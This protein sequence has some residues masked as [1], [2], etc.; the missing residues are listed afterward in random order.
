M[1]SIDSVRRS[2]S[3]TL[4]EI[5]ATQKG[6]GIDACDPGDREA[7]DIV[8]RIERRLLSRPAPK[9]ETAA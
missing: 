9:K 6:L 1:A 4:A 5:Q 2:I 3:A 8:C 7:Y